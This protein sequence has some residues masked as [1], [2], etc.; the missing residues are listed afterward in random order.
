MLKRM[1]SQRLMIFLVMIMN[2]RQDKIMEGAARWCSYY[3][4]NPHQFAKDY[5]HLN[6]K[7]FQKIV[8]IFMNLCNTFVFVASRGI[9]KTFLSAV[10][11]CTRCI[12]YPGTKICIA[13]GSRG[14]A[15]LVIEKIQNE[16]KSHS[17]ELC[18][19]IDEKK[20]KLSQSEGV[21][22]FKNGSFIKVVTASDNARGN[23]ANI[24]LID[25]YRMVSKDVI[26]TVL[27]KFLTN[28]RFPG[29]LSKPE[30]KHLAEPNKSLYLSSAYF[31]DHWSY[32]KAQDVCRMMLDDTRHAFVCGFPYQL[33][34]EDGIITQEKIED[35]M[36]ESDFSEVKWQMEMEAL[37]FGDSADSFFDFGSISK[38][39]KIQYPYLPAQLTE[40][41]GGSAKIK[42]PIKMPGE[43]RILSADIALMSSKKNNN[44]ATA[45]FINQM[46]PT[47]TKRYI[48]NIVYSEVYEGAHT[49]DQALSIR[50]LYDE[51]DCDYIVVDCAGV[52]MSIF[53]ALVR[54]IT[55]QETGDIYPALTCYNNAEMASRCAV[56]GA[57]KAI[58]AMKATAALNSECALL[59]REG[60]RSGK[61]R[62]LENEYDADKSLEDIKG[63]SGL[64]TDL[65]MKFRLP[66]IHTTLLV[67]EL[68]KLQHD[69]SGGKV[70]VFERAGM[71]KDRYSSLAYNF[72]VATQLE[73]KVLKER[74]NRLEQDNPF[75]FKA[76]KLK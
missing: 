29:Y 69:E 42:I 37:F 1:T 3:R 56:K 46:T 59:L 2:S 39:R 65:K 58:W 61:I 66:Y 28:P 7:T 6:L 18:A 75:L 13:S 11:C 63:F 53:D 4:A 33:A 35:D 74:A 68:V 22:S 76:P 23:R 17:P 54:D 51:Y 10:F 12:L 60:F 41:V 27:S 64:S 43:K 34:L 21:V 16:L 24:L 30:Y 55:D 38:N 8:L 19:E 45:V 15:N 67:D 40:L 47:R 14:Q 52:G 50:K 73:N 49:E 62:L 25:E 26:T 48:S 31:K 5:L 57:K 70:R 72:Y 9:G 20:S 32:A 36:A 71:R 44:D